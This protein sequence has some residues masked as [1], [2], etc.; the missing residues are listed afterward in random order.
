MRRHET[1]RESSELVV[2]PESGLARVCCLVRGGVYSAETSPR[3]QGYPKRPGVKGRIERESLC[4]DGLDKVLAFHH[5]N[6]HRQP[7]N[8]QLADYP[9][10]MPRL[11]VIDGRNHETHH[12]SRSF[13]VAASK[14]NRRALVRI[15]ITLSFAHRRTMTRSS[16]MLPWERLH[17]SGF[18]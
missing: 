4:R 2:S 12:L 13:T 15:K 10:G 1:D 17:Q 18:S 11:I 9:A 8:F 5:H 3:P 7:V 6:G 16:T 14:K